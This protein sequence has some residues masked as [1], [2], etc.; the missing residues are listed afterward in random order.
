M[1]WTEFLPLSWM[2]PLFYKISKAEWRVERSV[3]RCWEKL[4]GNAI[5]GGISV[6]FGS[7]PNNTAHVLCYDLRPLIA[8]FV[9]K[10]LPKWMRDFRGPA[11]IELEVATCSKTEAP[12]SLTGPDGAQRCANA[13]K[14]NWNWFQI[15]LA[16][17]GAPS[18]Y[19]VTTSCRTC[20]QIP[21]Q[22]TTLPCMRPLFYNISRAELRVA[23]SVTRCSGKLEGSGVK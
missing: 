19:N 3:P 7:S 6:P 22:V 10:W 2:Q 17:E 13:L 21:L 5:S 9:Q 23:R 4:E 11:R 16:P 1:G 14:S 15:L 8:D 18:S 12:S 20:L